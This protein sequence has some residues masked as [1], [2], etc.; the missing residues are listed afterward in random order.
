MSGFSNSVMLTSENG[1]EIVSILGIVSKELA[2]IC[3]QEFGKI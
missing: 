3:L 2:L 1:F